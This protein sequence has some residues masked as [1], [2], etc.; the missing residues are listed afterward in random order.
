MEV[1][2]KH[3]YNKGKTKVV[4]QLSLLHGRITTAL[5]LKYTLIADNFF[6][7]PSSKQHKFFYLNVV[8]KM[9]AVFLFLVIY[10]MYGYC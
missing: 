3:H 8:L 5:Y 9:A 10:K 7:V 6:K 2:A 1:K 4:I